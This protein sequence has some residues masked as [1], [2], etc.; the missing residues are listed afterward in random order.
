MEIKKLINKA[1]DVAK[2]AKE[3]S[4]REG[5]TELTS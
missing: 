4:L 2:E 1:T 5:I 3:S